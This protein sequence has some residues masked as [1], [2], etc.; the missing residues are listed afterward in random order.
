MTTGRHPPTGIHIVRLVERG[1][2]LL[3]VGAARI[4]QLVL[5]VL[6]L[7]L[8]HLR[9]NLLH[10]HRR[11]DLRDAQRQ[12]R[13]VDHHRDQH[14]RPTPVGDPVLLRPAH[15][16]KQRTP[17]EA[18]H[19]EV[20]RACQ[21]HPVG[22]AHRLQHAHRLGSGEQ[23]HVRGRVQVPHGN[24][25][26]LRLGLFA[27]RI[28]RILGNFDRV[29]Q[30]GKSSVLR[31]IRKEYGAEIGIRGADPLEV[32]RHHA[33]AADRAALLVQLQALNIF[34]RGKVVQSLIRI[35]RQPAG[36]AESTAAGCVRI[37]H[38][39]AESR[40]PCRQRRH[41]ASAQPHAGLHSNHI[42][43][44]EMQFLLH[45]QI[46]GGVLEG[47]ILGRAVFA[48]AAHIERAVQPIPQRMRPRSTAKADIRT[49]PTP[50][51]APG[52][53]AVPN[54]PCTSSESSSSPRRRDW[55]R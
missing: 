23:A 1:H 16:G 44:V 48:F 36:G 33:A 35:G 14:N 15:P 10:L 29:A 19:A 41:V 2:F 4:V 42:A 7:D 13:Q 22:T 40:R 11:L 54:R 26:N 12:Q 53:A 45:H 51:G 25:Q 9:R 50:A 24:S 49:R 20:Q 43:L 28:G 46:A 30:L 55:S 31:M 39:V 38:R 18:E 32:A 47:K 3:H 6:L 21:V 52:P 27:L 37:A 34:A 8:L 5:L 17:D